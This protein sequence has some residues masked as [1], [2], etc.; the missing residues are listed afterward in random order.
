MSIVFYSIK[1]YLN[2]DFKIIFAIVGGG[3]MI[4][5]N[6][7]KDSKKAEKIIN[8]KQASLLEFFPRGVKLDKFI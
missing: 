7:W 2:G 1:I 5:I 3:I 8:F 4:E 6:G